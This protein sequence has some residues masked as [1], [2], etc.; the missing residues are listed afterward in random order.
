MLVLLEFYLTTHLLKE[1]LLLE[2][3]SY[4]LFV[5][6]SIA[7]IVVVNIAISIDNGREMKIKKKSKLP[8]L[9]VFL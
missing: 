1:N 9:I 2:L 7:K 4:Q 3:K 5:I 8:Y 6:K